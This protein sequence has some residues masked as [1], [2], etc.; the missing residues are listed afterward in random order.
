MSSESYNIFPLGDSALTIDF[1]NKIDENVNNR[2]LS[3]FN[4][5]KEV[6]YSEILDIVP[7]YTSLTV[8]YNVFSITNK[9]QHNRT[10]FEIISEKVEKVINRTGK[11]PSQKNKQILKVPVCYLPE[12]GL[13]I[14]EIAREKNISIE[15]VVRLHS[16]KKYRVY[17]IGFLPG[18]PYMGEVDEKISMSRKQQPRVKVPAG[19][20]GIAANQTGI[21]P[22]D[23][24]GGW[25]I[26]GQTPLQIFCKE[27]AKLTF[28]EAGDEVEFYSISKDEFNNYSAWNT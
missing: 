3:L 27:E 20:V 19:S 24:P 18:F 14:Q 8:H 13:D 6:N 2:V 25:N 22:F 23:S 16:G 9:Y 10:A 11:S 5:L 1:G 21:Y 7:S 17:M 15:E 4:Q 26:I 12:F 28:F